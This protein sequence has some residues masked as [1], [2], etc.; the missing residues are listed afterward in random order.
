[1]AQNEINTALSELLGKHF[2]MINRLADT[3]TSFF[4]LFRLF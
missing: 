3:A 1:M 4:Q 2:E